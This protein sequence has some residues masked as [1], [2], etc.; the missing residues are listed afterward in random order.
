VRLVIDIDEAAVGAL[1]AHHGLLPHY[2]CD[3]RGQL[4]AA[5]A[6]LIERLIRAD[7]EQHRD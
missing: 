3:D 4:N 2:R 5:V 7:A 6:E 1:L